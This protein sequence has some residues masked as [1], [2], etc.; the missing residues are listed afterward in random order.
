MSRTAASRRPT[1]AF[2]ASAALLALLIAAVLVPAAARADEG[3]WTF[4]HLPLQQLQE[5]YGFTPTP[6]WVEHVQKASINFGGGSGA[7]VSPDGLALT[8]HHVALG[9][10]A[11]MSSPGPRLRPRR[12]LRAHPRRG[13]A[14]S[15]PRAQGADDQRGRDRP[16]PGRGGLGG[17]RP[18]AERPAQGGHG[19]HRAGGEPRRAQGRGGRALPRRRVLALPL[20]DLQGRAPGVRAR[21]AGRVLR[22]RPRQL[23]LSRATTWTSP[24]SAS[25][26]TASRS[27]RSTGSAGAGKARARATSSSWRA[28]RARPSGSTPWP[29]SSTS[30]P[31]T[32]RCGSC[33]TSSASRP[34][35]PTR[36]AGP[37]RRARR[38]TGSAGSRTTSSASTASSRCSRIPP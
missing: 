9:Q 8:N 2:A 6:E 20:Q 1:R 25:T 32:C 18:G 17:R 14:L 35:A 5:R 36:R 15:R 37:S 27:T 13:A 12:L 29:S 16:R 23:L 38:A 10:L 26:R 33:S 19:P 22:R 4:D 11:K 7:F 34:T 28:T 24:S 21:G 30:G 31:W 3:M